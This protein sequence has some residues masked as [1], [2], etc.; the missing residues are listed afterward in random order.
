MK[1]QNQRKIYFIYLLLDGFFK[2]QNLECC[3]RWQ[4]GVYLFIRKYSSSVRRLEEKLW[5]RSIF[6][7]KFMKNNL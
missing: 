2:Y 1:T 3:I 6:F 4:K 5:F 7:I